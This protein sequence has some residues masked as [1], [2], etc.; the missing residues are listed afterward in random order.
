VRPEWWTVVGA[1]AAQ[2]IYMGLWN[3]Y[4]AVKDD[5]VPFAS[6]FLGLVAALSLTISLHRVASD[7]NTMLLTAAIAAPV[8][9]AAGARLQVP[10]FMTFAV[11][12]VLAHLVGVVEITSRK[13]TVPGLADHPLWV[14]GLAGLAAGYAVERLA[15][16]VLRS[17]TGAIASLYFGASISLSL[18]M[19]DWQQSS[20][21]VGLAVQTLILASAALG[22]GSGW[23]MG[24]S[25]IPAAVC[26]GTADTIRDDLR[27]SDSV[28]IRVLLSSV[29]LTLASFVMGSLPRRGREHDAEQRLFWPAVEVVLLIVTGNL[30]LRW[31][32]A[33]WPEAAFLPLSLYPLLLM[34]GAVLLRRHA[35]IYVSL[36]YVVA[37]LAGVGRLT[38][39]EFDDA[40][41]RV[42]ATGFSMLTVAILVL[43][44]RIFAWR[45]LLTLQGREEKAHDFVPEPAARFIDAALPFATVVMLVLSV[46]LHPSVRE[47]LFTAGGVLAGFLWVGLGI[48]FGSRNYRLAGVAVIC[49]GIVKA[50]L[51]DVRELDNIYRIASFLT[52]GAILIIM[53]YLYNRFRLRLRL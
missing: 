2:L 38:L 48:A 7:P 23:L 35:V 53:P 52:L 46:R 10:G 32:E 15:P 5:K 13:G 14:L 12:A 16:A 37:V 27:I 22:V 17:R 42:R 30:V 33:W 20:L 36:F 25:L 39:G 45:R 26:F 28:R 47:V 21:M 6:H 19:R 41:A 24:A 44:E 9:A 31:A 34:F 40:D 18:L 50:F 29:A 1:V 49:F 11:V 43:T 8:V 51:Y 3:R 4:H